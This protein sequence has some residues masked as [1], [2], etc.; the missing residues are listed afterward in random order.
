MIFPIK[1]KKDGTT[2]FCTSNGELL[3]L[4]TFFSRSC[5][6]TGLIWR[7]LKK[8]GVDRFSTDFIW[9]QRE[10]SKNTQSIVTNRLIQFFNWLTHSDSTLMGNLNVIDHH[11]AISDEWLNYYLNEVLTKEYRASD[12]ALE[13]HLMALTQYYDYLAYANLSHIRQLKITRTSKELGR[14]NSKKKS[15]IKYITPSLRS[16]IYK[17]AKLR[18][19]RDECILRSGGQLG[20]RSKENLGFV[21]SDFRGPTGTEPGLKF[22]FHEMERN[23]KAEYKFWLQGRFVKQSNSSKGGVG[24]YLY[25]PHLLLEKYK[26]YYLEERPITES[27]SLFV[28]NCPSYKHHGKPISSSLG[29]SVFRKIRKLVIEQQQN[30][31]LDD[32][33]QSLEMDHSYHTLRHSFG[34]DK[35]YEAANRD[36]NIVN[37]VTTTHPIYLYISELLGHSCNSKFGAASQTTRNY[38]HSCGYKERFTKRLHQ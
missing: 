23:P 32:D 3:L 25:I 20:V 7:S 28:N 17:A 9:Q 22:L 21:L 11:P 12:S 10:I 33:E 38:I 35:F 18:S 4:P 14:G 31:K 8:R 15:V 1:S 29:T 13:Q 37:A 36:I 19:L 27:N 5:A 6:R 24:R 16:E 30:G 2:F 34:T 26:R